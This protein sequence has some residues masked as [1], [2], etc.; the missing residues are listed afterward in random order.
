MRQ[1]QNRGIQ[2]LEQHLIERMPGR[3]QEAG[4]S[5]SYSNY[6]YALAGLIVENISGMSFT[7]FVEQKFLSTLRMDHSTYDL[8]ENDRD[9]FE[10][11]KGYTV[12]NG[13]F[14]KQPLFYTH[15]KPAGGLCS[16][17]SDMT[18]LMMMLL[19]DGVFQGERLLQKES[20][21][22]MFQRQFSNHPKLTGYTLGFEEQ[23]FNGYP[24][25][26]KGGQTLGFVSVLLLFPEQRIGVF[27][28]TNGSSDDFIEM[29]IQHFTRRFF[30][31]DEQT[32]P[33]STE[34]IDVN[35]KRLAGTYRNN[36]YNH[37][38]IEDLVAL[39]RESISVHATENGT[40]TC[41]HSGARQ[42]YK[43]VSPLIFQNTQNNN[44]FLIFKENQRGQIVLYRNATFAG[45]SLPLS[46]EKVAWY[47]SPHFVN[48]FFLSFLVL[49]LFIYILV[50]LPW[51]VI[52]LIRL[53]K[54]DFWQKRS[55]PIIAHLSA[56][57]FGILA[58]IYTL[59]YVA[60]VNHMGLSL[61]FGM[62]DDLLRLNYISFV[63]I[64][65]SLSLFYYTFR[66][67]LQKSSFLLARIY[68]T[69]YS[70]SVIIFLAWL[71]SWHFIGF[72]V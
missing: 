35:S 59:G 22:M 33:S 3:F 49:Y 27:I 42:E 11:A 15:T 47:S 20:I 12:K 4:K 34:T 69:S 10:Y 51:L 65:L 6:S 39:F 9:S 23:W 54:K 64:L 52:F 36:R 1:K 60:R 8:P 17:A 72:H 48:E 40:L 13:E 46:Y 7:K 5:I 38:T 58:L 41:F 19:N 30:K 57:L 16:S 53:K 18:N 21:E 28:T 31:A 56:F 45:L 66:I 43:P 70:F 24:A 25:V 14:V 44:D 26:A 63:L 55:L 67:W 50:P 62:P 29:F 61:V 71:Y 68:Y 37:H 32:F 2:P